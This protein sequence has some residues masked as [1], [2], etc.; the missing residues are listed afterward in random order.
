MSM[1]EKMKDIKW[2]EG[3]IV[4]IIAVN[5]LRAVFL[6]PFSF[7]DAALFGV[8]LAFVHTARSRITG[9]VVTLYLA[10][11][12]LY[13]IAESVNNGHPNGFFVVLAIFILYK[14]IRGLVALFDYHK[15][16]VVFEIPEEDIEIVQRNEK[17]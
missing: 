11:S 5:F 12:Y 14:M 7:I 17:I 6:D 10:G 15:I 9:V 3:I 1:R 13:T 2:M 4:Y 16:N 8:A